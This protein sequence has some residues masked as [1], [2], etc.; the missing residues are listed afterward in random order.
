MPTSAATARAVA[1]LSPVIITTSMPASRSRAHRLARRRPHAVGQ[2]D[3]AEQRVRRGRRRRRASCRGVR[4][5]R[6]T[7]RRRCPSSSRKAGEPSRSS[8]A[9]GVDARRTPLPGTDTKSCTGGGRD[10]RRPRGASSDRLRE[11]MREPCSRPAATRSTSSRDAP[12]RARSTSVTSGLP[13]VSVP[14][15]STI[16]VCSRPGVLERGRVADQDARAARRARCRP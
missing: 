9:F 15:L 12:I 16:S 2:R 10:A 14:V 3:D 4:A 1:S 7:P 6:A 8:A 13:S 5:R 11:R